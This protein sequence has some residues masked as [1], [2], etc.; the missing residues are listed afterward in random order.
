MYVTWREKMFVVNFPFETPIKWVYFEIFRI[1]R[2]QNAQMVRGQEKESW[3]KKQNVVGTN[4]Q[5][6]DACLG[7]S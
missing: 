4:V 2:L 5:D 1:L 3:S 7:T 6:M